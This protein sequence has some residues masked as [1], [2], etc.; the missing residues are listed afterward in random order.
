MAQKLKDVPKKKKV[1]TLI[2]F[3]IAIAIVLGAVAFAK[4]SKPTWQKEEDTKISS[5]TEVQR[6]N[7]TQTLYAATL[8]E[9]KPTEVTEEGWSWKTLYDYVSSQTHYSC[10]QLPDTTPSKDAVI[11]DFVRCTK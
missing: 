8:T 1:E 4:N 11:N 2:M 10:Y 7:Y 3:A 6:Y 9:E 5:M